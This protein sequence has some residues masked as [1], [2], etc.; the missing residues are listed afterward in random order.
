MPMAMPTMPS[1]N[2][3]SRL[4]KYSHDT[5]D[6]V[7]E[8]MIAPAMISSCGPEFATMPANPLRKK[9]RIAASN[10]TRSGAA[11]LSPPTRSV[12]HQQLQ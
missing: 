2:S 11:S 12:K 7:D 4:A 3:I 6:G 10:D 5:A 8:A 1:G 9:P